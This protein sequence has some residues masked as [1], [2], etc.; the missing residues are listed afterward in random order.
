MHS[1]KNPTYSS[2]SPSFEKPLE[3]EATVNRFSKH[4]A[5]AVTDLTERF[6]WS[7]PKTMTV[8]PYHIASV[9]NQLGETDKALAYLEEGFKIRDP[10]MTFLK[11]AR[12]NGLRDDKRF[13]DLLRRVGF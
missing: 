8:P 4:S 12:W 6:G 9:Y 1:S 13:Q 11:D 5:A 7:R 2:I 10:K 3:I